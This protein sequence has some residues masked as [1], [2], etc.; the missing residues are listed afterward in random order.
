MPN[1][2][3]EKQTESHDFLTVGYIRGHWGIHGEVTVEV[4][5]DFPDRFEPQRKLYLDGHPLTIERSHPHKGY[6]ILKLSTIDDIPSADK[7][8]GKA[9]EI[10]L[11]EAH[12]LPEGEYYRFQLVGLE[13]VT[14]EGESVGRIT[15]IL[16]TASNDVYIVH[17][18]RGEILIPAISD[19]VKSIDITK[20]QLIIEVISGLL[21]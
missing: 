11:R 4:M 13:V 16:P 20:G 2:E 21:D 14:T 3:S 12:T 7:L 18:P 19:V 8:R 15:E 6:F 1:T 17:G 10:P 9:L 5:T